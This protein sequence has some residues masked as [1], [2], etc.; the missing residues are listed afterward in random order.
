MYKEKKIVAII[1]ARGGSKRLPNKN[2]LPLCSKPLI[3][4]SIE[5]AL[6]SHYVDEVVLS[7]DS[8][9]ILAEA[10]Q[11]E[12]VTLLKRPDKL[13]QDESRSID[14]VLHAL[15]VLENNYDYAIVLQPTSPLRTSEDIDKGIRECIDKDAISVIGVCE[16]EH[17]PLWSNQL[18]ESMD[19][20]NFLDDKYNNSRSQDLPIY[21]RINGAFYISKTDSLIK[22]ETFF[23]KE[24]IYALLMSQE[25]SVD[26]DTKL[27]F[28]TAQAILKERG[29]CQ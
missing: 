15:E 29:L 25:D 11:Y 8:D 18:D 23:V 2:I 14:V 7:S 1:P 9:T 26:I 24:K 19:M 13:A 16:V 10:N 4:W 21:Y 22:N 6:A 12:G 3:G 5:A 27:D 28:I 17:S 20:S